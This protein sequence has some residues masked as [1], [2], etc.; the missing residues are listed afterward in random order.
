MRERKQTVKK[1]SAIFLSF[2]MVLCMMP[3][4]AFADAGNNAELE[5][6]KSCKATITSQ[7][8]QKFLHGPLVDTMVKADLAETYGYTDTV[9]ASEGA[10]VLDALVQAHIAKYGEAFTAETAKT[11]LD[12]DTEGN[13]TRYFGEETDLSGVIINGQLSTA[14][15]GSTA[16]KDGDRLE[17]FRYASAEKKDIYTGFSGSYYTGGNN[18][19]HWKP[20]YRQNKATGQEYGLYCFGFLLNQHGSKEEI[21]RLDKAEQMDG[22]QIGIIDAKTGE[23]TP[24]QGA[25]TGGTY[26]S[27]NFKL[28]QTEGLCYLTAL[29]AEKDVIM[30]LLAFELVPN[31]SLKV[32]EIY[33]SSADYKARTNPIAMTPALQD[34]KFDGYSI[35]IPDYLSD[36]GVYIYGSFSDDPEKP[37]NEYLGEKLTQMVSNQWGGWGNGNYAKL[38]D[39]CFNVY[40]SGDIGKVAD[41]KIKANITATL[42]KLEMEGVIDKAFSPDET[43]YHSYID[44]SAKTTKIKATGNASSHTIKVNGTPFTSGEAGDLEVVWDEKD[45]MDVEIAVSTSS[46]EERIYRIRY[47]KEPATEKPTV[48]VQPKSEDY[49][50]GEKAAALQSKAS[51]SGT[52]TYQWYKNNK[53]AEDGATAI[54]GANQKEYTP[55]TEEI[56]EAYYFCKFTN[57]GNQEKTSISDIVKIV[58]DV[59][60]TPKA[61]FKNIGNTLDDNYAYAWKKGFIYETGAQAEPISIELENP[62]EGLTYS[63]RWINSSRATSTS[64]GTVASDVTEI[65]PGTGLKYANNTGSFYVCQIEC[66]FKGKTYRSYAATGEKTEDN[67]DVMGVYVFI[68][69]NAAST[70]EFSTQPTGKEDLLVGD[71][72]PALSIRVSRE[73]AGDLTY[74]WYVNTENSNEGGTKV[75]GAKSSVYYAPTK[76]AGTFYYYC[77]ATNHLQGHTASAVSDVAK[78]VVTDLQS[79]ADQKL[80]E[81]EVKGDGTKEHPY[82]IE[83]AE[84]LNVVRE[85]VSSRYAFAGK[86][87]SLEKDIT[88]PADWKPMGVTLNGKPDIQK[89]ANLAPF[90]GKLDGKDH[91][92]TVPEG[93]LPLLGYIKEAEVSNLKIYGKKIAGYGLVN[94]FEGVGLSGSAIIIDN[95]TLVNGTQT[96][97]AGLIGANITTNG[98]AGC[99]A[100]FTATIKNCTIEKDVII[101]YAENQSNI[102]AFAG[103]LQGTIENCVNHGTVKGVSYVGGIIGSRDNAMGACVVKDCT[104]D[105]TVTASGEQAG[106]II[107]G[108]YVNSTAPNGVRTYVT[109]N[110]ASGTVT[111][112]NYV[113]GIMG[114]DYYVNQNWG[115]GTFKL[116]QFT[117]KV[118]ATDGEYVGGVIGYLASLNKYD[119]VAGNYYAKDCGAEKGIGF[120]KYVDTSCKTHETESGA[121]YVNTAVDKPSISGFS[122]DNHNR[123]DDPLGADAVRLT[124]SDDQKD[125]IV[126]DLAISGDYKTEYFVG[127]AFSFD[128]MTITATYHTGETKE[129]KPS[130]VKVQDFDSAKRGAQEVKLVYDGISAVVS[131][132]V[133][134]P[135]G[136]DITVSVK[137]LGDTVHGESGQTH[138]LAQNNLP[139]VWLDT[140]TITVSN[141]ATVREA[142]EKAIEGTDISFTNPSGN[143]ISAVTKG[144]VTLTEM[145]NGK[146]SGWMYTLNG[147]H[148]EFGVGEQYLEKGNTI[149]LHYTD[150]YTKE[151]DASKW[152]TP[153]VEPEN[154]GD[155]DIDD[156][157]TPLDPGSAAVKKMVKGLKLTARSARTAKKNVKVTVKADK[158]T[159]EVIKDLKAMGYTVKYRYYR[160]TKKATGYKSVKTK[161]TSSY[162]SAVG[163]KGK[164]YYYKVQLRIYDKDGKLVAKTALKQCKYAKRTWT[165]K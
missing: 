72:Q 159:D 16:I 130:E 92:I 107:G 98:F 151:E 149:I 145:D 114:A 18:G 80:A 55:S 120:V 17:F 65:T 99:S 14:T 39:G 31:P 140:K 100:G 23:V 4:M 70:P 117:G 154:P 86:Y 46:Y 73:D 137:I 42:K 50:Q 119:N 44:P 165:K 106:G 97:K 24:I 105:G 52:V 161:K 6:A 89:G 34:G 1:I 19:L 12:V 128:G 102:G 69:A 113:G 43:S 91:T 104:F 138:T 85:L 129:L 33:R 3:S 90:S 115:T 37:N 101:G 64:G 36:Q 38:K 111:G 96:L 75:D 83:T 121:T 76:E 60:P 124:Y 82:Q 41:Y 10:S 53:N 157:N 132:M 58:V 13:V 22:L 56:G 51:A 67:K 148:P 15:P 40:Y 29:S 155:T 87:L 84:Q 146:N 11:K 153:V 68:K 59:D 109:G 122:K 139:E 158:A 63:Y 144:K 57:D 116:N 25:V 45:C 141:N 134:K 81:A 71:G 152:D 162:I 133:L 28:D 88:L 79:I 35:D 62:I 7:A 93:G 127:E 108:A 61:V 95:V 2:V 160:S 21:E 78:V 143:Y 20:M 54:E 150:D 112:K 103:R 74:Q 27:A 110:K 94:N 26:A 47:E 48:L 163:T 118:E 135:A 126:I 49:I 125:P 32:L 131:V 30:P 136:N 156:P 147:K 8:N 123:T 164:T 9:N 66:K 142:L 77:I 5:A